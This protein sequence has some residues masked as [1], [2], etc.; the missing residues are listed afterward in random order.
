M[1]APNIEDTVPSLYYEADHAMLVTTSKDLKGSLA[2]N[3]AVSGLGLIVDR[4][5]I[6]EDSY[7]KPT[8]VAIVEH[9]DYDNVVRFP[10]L[11]FTFSSSSIFSC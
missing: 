8:V 4:Y 2:N 7:D 10:A 9:C 3:T 11:S 1:I 5:T 6:Q